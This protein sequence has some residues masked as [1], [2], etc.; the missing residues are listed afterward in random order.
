MFIEYLLSLCP[1]GS[2]LAQSKTDVRKS[3]QDVC[4]RPNFNNGFDVYE[5]LINILK[6]QSCSVQVL[7]I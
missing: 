1:G 2:E 5:H 7:S 3:L 6:L 4:I